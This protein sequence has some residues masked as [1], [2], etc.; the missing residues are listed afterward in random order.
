MCEII[1]LDNYCVDS[2]DSKGKKQTLTN[3]SPY[4]CN[5]APQSRVEQFIRDQTVITEMW[6]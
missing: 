1:F 6:W 4:V 5:C 2:F 3:Y